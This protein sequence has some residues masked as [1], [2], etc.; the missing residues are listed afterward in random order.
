MSFPNTQKAGQP[1][2]RIGGS[3]DAALLAPN[4]LNEIVFFTYFT[5]MRRGALKRLTCR[6]RN[7]ARAESKRFECGKFQPPKPGT[8][9]QGLA[10]TH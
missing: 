5:T 7:L 8:R 10:M 4:F 6:M 1:R 9:G 2:I 3:E